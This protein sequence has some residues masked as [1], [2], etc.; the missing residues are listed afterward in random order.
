MVDPPEIKITL[1]REQ[2]EHVNQAHAEFHHAFGCAMS[3][4]AGVER[5]LFYWFTYI[6]RMKSEMARAVFYSAR[7]FNARADMLAA[8]IAEAKRQTEVELEFI[9]TALK[10][11]RGYGGFRNNLAHGEPIMNIMGPK[12]APRAIHYSITQGKKPN[13]GSDITIADLLTAAKNFHSLKLI[14]TEALPWEKRVPEECLAQLLALPTQ[15]NSKVTRS[16]SKPS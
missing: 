11:A 16:P 6:T 10:R 4:W 5:S 3:E 15:A 1:T 12:E 7:S 13:L 2:I 8:A 14:I 9:R